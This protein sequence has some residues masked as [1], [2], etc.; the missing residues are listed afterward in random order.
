MFLNFVYTFLPKLSNILP[1]LTFFWTFSENKI[2]IPTKWTA[3]Q[4]FYDAG[5]F[6]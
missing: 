5:Y 1:F 6:S 2:R 4:L 3:V